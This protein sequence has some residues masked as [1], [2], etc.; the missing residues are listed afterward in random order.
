[1]SCCGQNTDANEESIPKTGASNSIL[2]YAN[3]IIQRGNYIIICTITL[4]FVHCF[5]LNQADLKMYVHYC[6]N[7]DMD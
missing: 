1:M 6:L 4:Y 2:V 3:E 7:V 5:F